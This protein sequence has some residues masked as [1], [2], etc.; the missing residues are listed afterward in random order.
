MVGSSEKGGPDSGGSFRV[1]VTPPEILGTG[2]GC[3][4]TG[5]NVFLR[6][7]IDLKDE[8]VSACRGRGQGTNCAWGKNCRVKIRGNLKGSPERVKTN[9]QDAIVDIQRDDTGRG[10]F[11]K[12]DAKKRSV[13][14][15]RL[16]KHSHVRKE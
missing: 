9:Q 10:L 5:G 4:Y 13:W 12:R 2:T 16:I 8:V 15:R 3:R 6:G 11:Q 1:F 14:R 7:S